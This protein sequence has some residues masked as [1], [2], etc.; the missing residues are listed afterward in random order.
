MDTELV[1]TQ[2][3]LISLEN[4]VTNHYETL[5]MLCKDMAD[6]EKR[7]YSI[8]GISLQ[9]FKSL[10]E[11][12]TITDD[13]FGNQE[14]LSRKITE[15]EEQHK[16]FIKY[17]EAKQYHTDKKFKKDTTYIYSTIKM[18]DDSEQKAPTN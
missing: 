13:M 3:R 11:M 10:K 1:K 14:F 9:L 7:W 16:N 12:D 18:E 5:L 15:I 6:L 2:K 17:H 8:A 4:M